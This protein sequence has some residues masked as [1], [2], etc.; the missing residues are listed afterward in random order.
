MA[1]RRGVAIVGVM[2]A[3]AILMSG[4]SAF[5]GVFAPQAVRD[6]DTAEITEGGQ[7][8]VFTLVVGDCF[9][10]VD[11]DEVTDL[12]VVPCDTSHDYEYF[13][14]VQLP[15]GDLP[16][17]DALDEA[18]QRECIPAFED[19][20]GLPYEDSKLGVSTLYPTQGSWDDGDR[21]L[22]CV[23]YDPEGSMTGSAKGSKE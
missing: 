14:V 5:E 20:V 11:A 12:P 9:N 23:L 6:P 2:V 17:E 3:G 8:D 7:A 1:A 16:D 22:Q 13:H 15:D 4:C 18:T 10:E 21:E 19:Y